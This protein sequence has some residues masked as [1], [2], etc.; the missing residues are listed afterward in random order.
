MHVEKVS[1]L[2][3]AGTMQ[4]VSCRGDKFVKECG[5]SRSL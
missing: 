2:S 4:P 5:F 3:T 1:G